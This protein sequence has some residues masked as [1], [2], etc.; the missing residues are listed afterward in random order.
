MMTSN[1]YIIDNKKNPALEIFSIILALLSYIH[2]EFSDDAQEA[3]V[4]L[5]T[6]LTTPG[7]NVVFFKPTSL[8]TFNTLKY[9]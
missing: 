7:S 8:K 3:M 2:F 1:V 6:Q 5:G 4:V 9:R